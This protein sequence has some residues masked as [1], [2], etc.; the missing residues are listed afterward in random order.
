MSMLSDDRFI[1]SI[2]VR[3]FLSYGASS[4]DVELRALNVL[5]GPNLSG[6]S[7]LLEAIHVLHV[8]P[9]DLAEHIREGGGIAEWIWKGSKSALNASITAVLDNPLGHD[10]IRYSLTFTTVG[11]RLEVIDEY[12]ECKE[13][14][15]AWQDDVYFYYRFQNGRP[16]LNVREFS[17]EASEAG[18]GTV[19]R[20][21]KREDL[22]PEQSVLSQRKD[23]DL[24]PE[25]TYVGAQFSEI[26]LYREWNLGRYTPPRLP[27]Q[28]DLP[29]HF[30]SEDARNLTLVLNDLE[31]RSGVKSVIMG[32]LRR[33]H[34][35]IEDFTTRIQ[36]GTVQLFLREKGLTEPVPATRLSDGTLRYL[37]L[38]AVLCH[39]EP[40]PV[41][42]I[43]EPELSLHPDAL[44]SIAELLIEASHRTQLIVTTHSDTL[45]SELSEVPE[46]IIVCERIGAATELRRLD[47]SRL[48]K[49]L[50]DYRLG[51]LWRMG[52][53]GG[54]P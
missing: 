52:E 28:P 4:D 34:H 48:E 27:Q 10:D 54:N 21:L 44:K 46:S 39:P 17:D 38:L 35:R 16:V 41:V 14:T 43:E 30:L 2:G 11:Q 13:K 18:S 24:Y 36:G 40:P 45:V 23:P 7:N 47:G 37:C 5:I 1:K 29:G 12:L 9:K 20:H 19:T 51:E 26:K 53:L 25:L 6:K 31:H 32:H 15:H 50:N 33:F 49:W 8:A 3:N 42:C 22:N